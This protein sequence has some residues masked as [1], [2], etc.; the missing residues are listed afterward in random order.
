MGLPKSID[1]E[2]VGLFEYCS[3]INYYKSTIM[4]D[5]ESFYINVETKKESV[6]NNLSTPIK[7][8]MD[9]FK[10][11]NKKAIHHIKTYNSEDN[12]EKLEKRYLIFYENG[13]FQIGYDAGESPAGNLTIYVTFHKDFS[14]EKGLIFEVY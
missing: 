10:M 12:S 2:G 5:G 11:L 9:N 13:S 6:I 14:A 1:I 8:V 4:L 7:N 3:G